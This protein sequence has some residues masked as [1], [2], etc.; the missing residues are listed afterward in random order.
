VR[1]RRNPVAGIPLLPYVALSAAGRNAEGEGG[2]LLYRWFLALNVGL[3]A[4]VTLAVILPLGVAQALYVGVFATL[5]TMAG[6]LPS[7]GRAVMARRHNR[8]VDTAEAGR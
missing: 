1:W 6:L 8:D 3:G 7:I 2:R 4:T 5:V